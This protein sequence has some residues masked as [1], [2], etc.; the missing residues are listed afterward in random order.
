MAKQT[1]LVSLIEASLNVGSGFII[2]MVVWQLVVAPMFGY[3]VTIR[4]NAALTS[5][6]TFVSIVRSYL[7]RRFFN[8]GLHKALVRWFK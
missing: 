6:F 1:R 5:I 4:D 8:A 2:A 3:H 7:W